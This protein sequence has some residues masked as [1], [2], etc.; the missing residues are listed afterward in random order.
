M[1]VLAGRFRIQLYGSIQVGQSFFIETY[2]IVRIAPVIVG[3]SESSVH[4]Y[5]PAVVLNRPVISAIAAVP[6]AAGVKPIGVY[7]FLRGW[8]PS[9]NVQ[10]LSLARTAQ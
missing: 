2:L 5:G 8:R 4:L 10:I 3:L 6:V 9:P 7:R 1:P